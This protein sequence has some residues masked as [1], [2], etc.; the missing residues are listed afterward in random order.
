MSTNLEIQLAAGHLRPISSSADSLDS[1]EQHSQMFNHA[2]P[3]R[4]KKDYGGM[5]MSSFLMTIIKNKG[6][7]RRP[8]EVNKCY[9]KN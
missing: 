4:P 3:T 8:V 2:P 9:G 1:K 7:E 5:N 6:V